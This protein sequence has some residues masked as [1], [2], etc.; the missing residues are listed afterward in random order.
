VKLLYAIAL[1]LFPVSAPAAAPAQWP[2]ISLL[3]ALCSD[4]Y[5]ED[6][7]GHCSAISAG[8]VFTLE[9]VLEKYGAIITCNPDDETVVFYLTD[10]EDMP[11]G[12]IYPRGENS[13]AENAV[14][15]EDGSSAKT[16]TEQDSIASQVVTAEWL[17]EQV[18]E[19]ADEVAT[20]GPTARSIP[21]SPGSVDDHRAIE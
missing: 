16:A 10:P 17:L 14:G 11:V 20:P 7:A 4:D 5:Y 18:D 3:S 2:D 6:T 13:T 12:S 15:T 8:K 9:A 19:T 21:T 1:S